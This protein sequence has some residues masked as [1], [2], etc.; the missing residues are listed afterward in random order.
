MA[1]GSWKQASKDDP[2]YTG[3]VTFSSHHRKKE[4]EVWIESTSFS[5]PQKV[6]RAIP[7]H[8][9]GPDY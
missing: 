9:D 7:M 4:E 8:E 3:K 5:K 1:K 6:R 2:N